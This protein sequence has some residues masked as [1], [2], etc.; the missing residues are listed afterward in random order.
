MAGLTKFFPKDR[1]LD[2]VT[3]STQGTHKTLLHQR[4][5][6]FRAVLACRLFDEETGSDLCH[7]DVQRG[8]L[9]EA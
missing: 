6:Q 1:V 7:W 2:L 4:P 5:E 8:R 3:P 9:D